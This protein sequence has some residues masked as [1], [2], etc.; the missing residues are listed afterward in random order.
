MLISYR[1]TLSQDA[2]TTKA[3]GTWQGATHELHI[4][5]LCRGLSRIP[6][7][8]KWLLSDPKTLHYGSQT[9]NHH[10]L[11]H[12]YASEQGRWRHWSLICPS[13]LGSSAAVSS[14]HAHQVRFIIPIF[15]KHM[16][17]VV[18]DRFHQ[19]ETPHSNMDLSTHLLSNLAS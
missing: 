1:R 5:A 8:F 10:H 16:T 15:C 19:I 18:W 4:A 12:T 6:T 13:I 11:P 14:C 3:L 9:S 17:L 2:V 7:D